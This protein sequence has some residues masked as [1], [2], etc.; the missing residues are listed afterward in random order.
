MDVT[1]NEGKAPR[2]L[3]SFST[4][5]EEIASDSYLMMNRCSLTIKADAAVPLSTRWLSDN[6]VSLER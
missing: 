3:Y 2:G 5:S 1:A 4:R 6:V